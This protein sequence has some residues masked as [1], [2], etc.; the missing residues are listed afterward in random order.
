MYIETFVKHFELSN[1]RIVGKYEALR[2]YVLRYDSEEY[3][4][5]QKCIPHEVGRMNKV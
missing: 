1:P 5:M 2:R 4:I 3:Q